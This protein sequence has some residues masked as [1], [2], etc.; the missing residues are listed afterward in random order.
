MQL[1]RTRH[2]ST[3]ERAFTLIELLVVIAIIAILASLLLPTLARAKH[4]A[5]AISCR[6]NNKQLAL[7]WIMYIGDN[8]DN[9][10]G[11]Y[12]GASAQNHANSNST[13]CVGWLTPF[14]T[15]S[16]DNTNIV[17]LNNSQLGG[18]V[19]SPGIYKC[20]ADKGSYVRS[21]AMNC[22]LGEAP[23]TPYTPGYIQF[24]RLAQLRNQ[25]F[26]PSDAF[27]FIDERSE[28]INDG[29]FLVSMSGYDPLAPTTSS[30]NLS[31]FPGIYHGDQA[32]LSFADGHADGRK[33]KDPRTKTTPA[34]TG[35]SAENAD[36]AWLQS[37]STRKA[38]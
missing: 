35:P 1:R 4:K 10:P 5:Q 6:N 16:P 25:G 11:N 36:V 2:R 19:R 12:Y 20:P 33:W 31:E 9:L 24:L 17:L 34:L 28:T 18:I 21:Y 26:S 32:T 23:S 29:S 7:A 15:T 30:Y 22:Y 14:P 13:W 3:D 8:N 37:H 38:N 27:I